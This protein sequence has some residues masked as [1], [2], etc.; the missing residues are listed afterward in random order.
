METRTKGPDPLPI[1]KYKLEHFEF[2]LDFLIDDP[3]RVAETCSEVEDFSSPNIVQGQL[4]TPQVIPPL[5]CNDEFSCLEELENFCL[6]EFDLETSSTSQS[7]THGY[8]QHDKRKESLGWGAGEKV[9]KPA[10]RP[11]PYDHTVYGGRYVGGGRKEGLSR[12]GAS[13]WETYR[14][15]EGKGTRVKR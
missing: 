11:S 14:E 1:I 10:I 12:V 6:F 8:I 7:M 2:D 4:N 9:T 15:G 5:A 13:R 3:D